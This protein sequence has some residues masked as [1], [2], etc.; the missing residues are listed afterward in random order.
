M[1]PS[2][3]I[4]VV[5]VLWNNATH[6]P[7]CLESLLTQTRTDFEVILVDNNSTDRAMADALEKYSNKLNLTARKLDSNLGFAAAN[8]IGARLARGTWLAL[9]NPD[10]FP[11]PDWLANLM[12]AA[13]QYG[14]RY[15]F[16][17][18]QIQ[19]ARPSLLD[20]EGDV[21][22]VSGLVWR[23]N[24][25]LPV[26]ETSV[27][28]ETFSA[29]GAAALFSREE[30]IAA[31]GFDERYFAYLEDVDLGF[32]LRLRGLHCI[33][34]PQAV[35]HHVG[36]ASSGQMSDFVVYHGHRNMIWTYF[37][38][39]PEIL[40]WLYLPLHILTN[41]F[42]LISFSFQGRAKIIFKS[43][44]DAIKGLPRVLRQRREVQRQ[45]RV[46]ISQ[47]HQAMNWNWL[48]PFIAK[49]RRLASLKTLEQ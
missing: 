21:Y 30:F 12:T 13:E 45:R 49:M 32:R 19:F 27:R 44:W 38:D 9:L 5:I 3:L 15:F 8:N 28:L 2:T 4:S 11:E 36:S 39:M 31:G 46:P 47:I 10:A 26:Y 37:K 16:S 14:G 18:R 41:V 23:R 29:C 22:H 1:P 33:F 24:Y 40:L 34:V 7:R 17:S 35:V 48:E 20:G 6:L 43:K 25:G 42:Y